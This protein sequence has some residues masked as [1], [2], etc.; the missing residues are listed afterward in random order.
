MKAKKPSN[1]KQINRQKPKV[2]EGN[3]PEKNKSAMCF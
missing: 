2:T 3:N 1:L